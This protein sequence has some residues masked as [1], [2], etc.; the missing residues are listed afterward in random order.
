MH[1]IPCTWIAKTQEFKFS[2]LHKVALEL[3]YY[4]ELQ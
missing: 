3:R 1:E 2:R 4:I